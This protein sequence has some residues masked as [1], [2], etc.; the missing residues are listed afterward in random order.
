MAVLLPSVPSPLPF[1][2]EVPFGL[3]HPRPSWDCGL[4]LDLFT[5]A[6]GL[7]L[8]GG[9]AW[10]SLPSSLGSVA[11]LQQALAL[12]SSRGQGQVLG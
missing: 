6:V 2:P 10:N 3:C 1:A 8:S 7:P 5:W 9:S 11:V 4:Q 12:D